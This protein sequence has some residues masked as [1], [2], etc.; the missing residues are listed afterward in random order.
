MSHTEGQHKPANRVSNDPYAQRERALKLMALQVVGHL[1]ASQADAHRVL[2]MAARVVD[3]FL[4]PDGQ[5]GMT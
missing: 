3:G 2:A 1:P 5:M 4:T